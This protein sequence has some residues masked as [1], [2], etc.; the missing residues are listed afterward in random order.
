MEGIGE[1]TF[2]NENANATVE[3]GE[4]VERS[5]G[6]AAEF[7]PD[8]APTA[9]EKATYNQSQKQATDKSVAAVSRVTGSPIEQSARL[10][11]TVNK[12]A[13]TTDDAAAAVTIN[14]APPTTNVT[15]RL[16]EANEEGNRAVT[17]AANS[18]PGGDS[19]LVRIQT[20][21]AAASE[22]M[23]RAGGQLT[24]QAIGFLRRAWGEAGNLAQGVANSELLRTITSGVRTKFSSLNFTKLKIFAGITFILFLGG[25]GLGIY[26]AIMIDKLVKT[27][28]VINQQNSNGCFL[29]TSNS[30]PI[31]LVGCSDWYSTD[32]NKFSCR[33]GAL[34]DSPIKP[35]C[36]SMPSEECKAPYCLGESCS[37]SVDGSPQKCV[38]KDNSSLPLYQCTSK[39]RD[40]PNFIGYAYSD[41]LPLE[42]FIPYF[43]INKQIY[44]DNKANKTI[45]YILLSIGIIAFAILMFFVVKYYIKL[46]K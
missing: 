27:V 9:A 31:R 24:P 38:R 46:K 22:D 4:A 45:L 18:I 34:T 32:D 1:R 15:V 26:D 25:I 2:T 44:D 29:L 12:A 21:V 41:T 20:N 19:A 16:V 35:N 10:S 37:S 5:A 23:R 39:N 30:D 28:L 42:P 8:R 40:D 13:A 3:F 17:S 7:P 36:T 43:F 11:D 14:S 6:I 33:C